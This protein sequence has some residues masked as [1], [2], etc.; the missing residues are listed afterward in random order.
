M[1]FLASMSFREKTAW[2][3]AI[4]LTLAG[5][6]YF[7]T[8]WKASVA[9]GG[10]APPLIYLTIPYVI[11]VVIA[12]IV[13]MTTLALSSPKEANAPADE[14]ERIVHDRAGNWSGYVLAFG[15]ICGMGYYF[16]RRDGDV[17]FHI[18]VGSLMLSQIVEYVF[19][20]VLL[21]RGA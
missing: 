4:I 13:S 15:V 8:L 18:V 20:I 1:S 21:R 6:Y 19:Q 10:L 11:L 12:S 3:M 2:V 17:F 16:A 9:L 7:H 5:A 14:R